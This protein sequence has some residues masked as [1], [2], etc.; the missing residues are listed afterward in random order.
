MLLKGSLKEAV[1]VFLFSPL[2]V[3]VHNGQNQ[4]RQ[5][6]QEFVRLSATLASHSQAFQPTNSVRKGPKS[7]PVSQ[8]NHSARPC[9]QTENLDLQERNRKG[10]YFPVIQRGDYIGV[11]HAPWRRESISSNP[12]SRR[13]S[14]P[15]G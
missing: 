13:H 8:A 9:T 4:R 12:S 10:K 15:R 3:C 1:V 14:L 5:L 11:R 7:L 6:N 2:F